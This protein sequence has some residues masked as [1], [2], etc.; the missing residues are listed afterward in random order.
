MD[1]P[2]IPPNT[3]PEFRD[4]L[5]AL[6]N[7]AIVLRKTVILLAGTKADPERVMRDHGEVLLKVE[8]VISQWRDHLGI[9]G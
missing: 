2:D 9:E 7:S 6:V 3:D 8:A 5:S 1:I 4:A